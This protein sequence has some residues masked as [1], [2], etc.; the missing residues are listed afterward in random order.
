MAPIDE[1]KKHG[2]EVSDAKIKPLVWSGVALAVIIVLA[3]VSMYGFFYVLDQMHVRHDSDPS[4]VASAK[5]Q[6]PPAPRLQVQP[7]R[8]IGTMKRKDHEILT[9]YGWVNKDD[10]TVRVPIERAKELV[11]KDGLSTR[12]NQPAPASP[13]PD[14][15]SAKERV[16][17]GSGNNNTRSAGA[18]PEVRGKPKKPKGDSAVVQSASSND[19]R[20]K[21]NKPAAQ[22]D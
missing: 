18:V 10:G 3:F 19:A 12:T 17:S 9:T 21:Q 11:L 20:V 4:P 14:D 8:D 13:E 15:R 6:L 7:L 22:S 1:S 5:G 16:A 2:Y